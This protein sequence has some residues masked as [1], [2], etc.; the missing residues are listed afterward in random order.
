MTLVIG[1]IL[2]AAELAGL[3][4]LQVNPQRVKAAVTGVGRASK[5]QVKRM[6]SKLLGV[7]I[8]NGHACDAAAV[9]I[10]GLLERSGVVDV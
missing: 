4:S 8:K 9:A 1:V 2:L 10:A 7:D 5:A 6:V 3:P